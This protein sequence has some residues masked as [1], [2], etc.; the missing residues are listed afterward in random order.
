MK[1]LF[2]ISDYRPKL[3]G[4]TLQEADV[5]ALHRW[6]GWP[7]API[8]LSQSLGYWPSRETITA[9]GVLASVYVVGAVY[10]FVLRPRLRRSTS[11][12]VATAAR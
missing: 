6:P 1:P 2:R 11:P 3:N 7:R 9:Q 4:N 8:F 5:I 10:L 12:A